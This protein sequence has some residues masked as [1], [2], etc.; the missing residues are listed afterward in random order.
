MASLADRL[1]GRLTGGV[2]NKSATNVKSSAP[3]RNSRQKGYGNSDPF[4]QSNQNQYS[5]GS[6]RYPLNLGSTEEFGHYMLFHIFER[7]NSKYHGPQ[8]VEEIIAAGTKKARW[9]ATSTLDRVKKSMK[10]K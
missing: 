9:V 7:T 6:L 1:I 8:E 3:I 2:L 10:L 5:Y 4:D